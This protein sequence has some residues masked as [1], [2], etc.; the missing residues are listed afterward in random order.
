MSS[1]ITALVDWIDQCNTDRF[2]N[3]EALGLKIMKIGEEFGEVVQAW[4]GY[5]G[6]NPRKGATHS[7][8]DVI[9]ELLDVALTAL[10][11]VESL[12]VNDVRSELDSHIRGVALRAG[13]YK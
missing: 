11:A 8:Q 4:I 3:R 12:G 1:D 7:R 5:V 6:Q 9:K 2:Y 10:V 13:V